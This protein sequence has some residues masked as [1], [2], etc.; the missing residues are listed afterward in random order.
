MLGDWHV[1]C[2][3][4]NASKS[5][6]QAGV[7]DREK[8]KAPGDAERKK[9]CVQVSWTGFIKFCSFDNIPAAVGVESLLTRT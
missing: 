9:V 6:T 3:V 1:Q 8:E 5:F 4:C 7:C 2:T